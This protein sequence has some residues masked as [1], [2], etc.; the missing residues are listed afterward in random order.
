MGDDMRR[1]MTVCRK[2]VLCEKAH[3]VICNPCCSA[4]EAAYR[5]LM[6]TLRYPEHKKVHGGNLYEN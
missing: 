1:I 3:G 4:W 5:A 6:E 2:G